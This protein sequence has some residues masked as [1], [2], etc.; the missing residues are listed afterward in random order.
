ME[1]QSANCSL[2]A[3]ASLKTLSCLKLTATS[4]K[5]W[6]WTTTM[7]FLTVGL[8]TMS[9]TWG[10]E[11]GHRHPLLT[12]ILSGSLKT[13]TISWQMRHQCTNCYLCCLNAEKE[14]VWLPMDYSVMFQKLWSLQH[15]SWL[16]FRSQAVG[17]KSQSQGWVNSLSISWSRWKNSLN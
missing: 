17:V 5:W 10:Y 15:R 2:T 14:L 11:V 13:S 8:P 9:G 6:S 7:M 3:P 1:L 16:K 4:N 12:T